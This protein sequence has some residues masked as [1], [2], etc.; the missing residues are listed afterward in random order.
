MPPFRMLSRG[1]VRRMSSRTTPRSATDATRFTSTTPQ[2]KS[3]TQAPAGK[4][5]PAG[6]TLEQRVQRLR[7]AHLA[8]RNAPLSTTDRIVE[9]GRKVFDTLHKVTLVVLIGFTGMDFQFSP[10]LPGRFPPPTLPL[11]PGTLLADK[12]KFGM[13]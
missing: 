5:A 11:A 6:E 12:R 1:A 9:T 10:H 2:P 8:A 3:K 4:G 7:A 13:L